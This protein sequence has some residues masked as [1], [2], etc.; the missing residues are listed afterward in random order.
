MLP[1][2]L[3]QEANR[4]R[5]RIQSNRKMKATTF[6]KSVVRNGLPDTGQNKRADTRNIQHER[7]GDRK[8]A[9]D[10]AVT[11]HALTERHKIDND[12]LEI[13]QHINTRETVIC[14]I[15]SSQHPT[16]LHQWKLR[17]W[18]ISYK[19]CISTTAAEEPHNNVV[20]CNGH[21]E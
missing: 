12:N 2:S 19:D 10:P 3:K 13:P 4:W 6:I 7:K 20:W 5:P 16:R 15:V 14:L 1:S 18:D 21:R 11:S 9:K 17:A 8:A